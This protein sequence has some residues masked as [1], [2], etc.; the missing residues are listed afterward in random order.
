MICLDADPLNR[1]TAKEIYEK[2]D[3]SQLL[4]D[5]ELRRQIEKTDAINNILLTENTQ[6]I[7]GLSYKTHSEAIYTSRSLDFNNLPEPKNSDDYYEKNDNIISEEFSES[8]QLRF[9][10]LNIDKNESLR[11]NLSQLSTNENE[12]LQINIS[13]LNINENESLQINISQLN[14]N[15]NE[16]S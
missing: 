4:Y 9:S 2:L 15:V 6:T 16:N 1:P 14:I 10:Q 5:T 13:Q 8:L 3:P 12:S 7:L 11:R